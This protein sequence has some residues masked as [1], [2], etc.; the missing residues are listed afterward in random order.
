MAANATNGADPTGHPLFPRAATEIGPDCR[1]FD[2]ILIQR[3]LPDGT[4][5]C[6][7]RPW[8]GAELRSWEQILAT[9]GGECMYQLVAMCAQTG[10]VQ[11]YS[12][13]VVFAAPA[14]KPFHASPTNGADTASLVRMILDHDLA[15]HERQKELLVLAF[16]LNERRAENAAKRARR[17]VRDGMRL[18]RA[19]WGGEE[20]PRP[21]TA[22]PAAEVQPPTPQPAPEEPAAPVKR[23]VEPPAIEP[24]ATP[25]PAAVEP[26]SPELTSYHRPS[27]PW[28]GA[29]RR[30]R[31][32]RSRVRASAFETLGRASHGLGAR[33]HARSERGPQLGREGRL[34]DARG[35]GVEGRIGGVL[36]HELDPL[37]NAG[38]GD[39]R[40]DAQ[41]Q[42]D[43][44]RDA[45]SRD[46]R[47]VHDHPVG[48]GLRAE[49]AQELERRPV[50]GRPLAAQEPRSTEHQRA[51]ADRGHVPGTRCDPAQERERLFIVQ[52]CIHAEPTRHA[53]EIERRCVRECGGGKHRQ[54]VLGLH[55]SRAPC[56]EVDL[57]VR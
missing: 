31:T 36:D 57:G 21:S 24:V 25:V 33:L 9:Y 56:D 1:R 19:I 30:A 46:D 8:L 2:F 35:A 27:M 47:A 14:R 32:V 55:R 54:A 16:E 23:P 50:R 26:A 5:E 41:C 22:R 42:V 51:R 15:M 18:G 12:E 28:R 34:G 13:R 52:Q 17:G 39:L 48:D 20:Q 4:F 38:P 40:D 6:C 44:S 10:S 37:G 3:W 43:P 53:N 7:P 29:P 45:C 11:A 49:C